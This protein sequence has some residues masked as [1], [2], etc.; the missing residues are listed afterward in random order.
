VF[1]PIV[2]WWLHTLAHGTTKG[3][4]TA[5]AQMT[6]S[7]GPMVD[8]NTL[9]TFNSICRAAGLGNLLPYE[10]PLNFDATALAHCVTANFSE[11][12]RSLAKVLEAFDCDLVLISGKPSELP[13]VKALLEDCL[14]ILPQR[15]MFA[16]NAEV[17][18]WYPLSVDGLVHDAKTVTVAGAALYRAIRTG[19]VPGWTIERTVSARLLTRNY[20]G[21][22][23]QGAKREFSQ[24]LLTSQEDGKILELMVPARIG[25]RKLPADLRPEPVYELRWRDRKRKDNAIV[26]V[27]L[28]RVLPENPGDPEFLAVDF[29]DGEP[30]QGDAN[31]RNRQQLELRL[32]TLDTDDYWMDA[33]R[34]DVL[35]PESSATA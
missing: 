27:A 25:R 9:E 33:G 8:A 31:S 6:G 34:F 35:W 28:R 20:W 22:M 4:G 32:C 2:R 14:P 24:T 10:A 15:I 29:L 3:P 16:H 12:F 21:I 26:K 13:A 30:V 19:L 1:I 17:G 5:P 11:T 7:D 23:P 18:D